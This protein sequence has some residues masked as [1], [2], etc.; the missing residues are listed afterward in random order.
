MDIHQIEMLLR[1]I[2]LGSMTKAA[3]EYHYTPSAFS[4]IADA[5]EDEIGTKIIKRTYRGIEPEN[6]EIIKKLEKLCIIR[7]EILAV[8]KNTEDTI[9]IGT[10]A[11]LAKYVLPEITKKF[12]KENPG[13]HI[14]IVVT[15]NM[16]ELMRK[17]GAD[18][19]FGEYAGVDECVFCE[20]MTDPYVAVFPKDAKEESFSPYQKYDRLFIIPNDTKTK[21][22]INKDNFSDIIEVNSHDDSLIVQMVMS[23]DGISVLS[24]ISVQEYCDK[25]KAIPLDRELQ[26]VLG[27]MYKKDCNNMKIVKAFV[28][29]FKDRIPT[30]DSF[31]LQ[32][33]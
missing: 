30:Y 27:L 18:I 7:D 26:R 16:G 2:K 31:H 3:E 22:Y 23:G 29:F 12:R 14:S 28:K 5:I 9:T 33:F 15:D 8:A 21:K 13:L 10:Y 25:I 17:N 1:A 6:E 24:C 4:H 32:E 11:S 19:Y 20:I